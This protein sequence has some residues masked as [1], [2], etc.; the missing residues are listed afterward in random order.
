MDDIKAKLPGGSVDWHVL[1]PPEKCGPCCMV[2][3]QEWLGTVRVTIAPWSYKNHRNRYW[4]WRIVRAELV[5]DF[6]SD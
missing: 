2:I 4:A 5:G 6:S 1:P 3:H